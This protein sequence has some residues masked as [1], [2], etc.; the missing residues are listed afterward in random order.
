M[1]MS[2]CSISSDLKRRVRVDADGCKISTIY[3]I[4]F[5]PGVMDIFVNSIKRTSA[6]LAEYSQATSLSGIAAICINSNQT[7][8][9]IGQKFSSTIKLPHDSPPYYIV[10]DFNKSDSKEIYFDRPVFD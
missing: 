10:V 4:H 5:P 8:H 3:F 1:I 9:L 6:T 7:V 2:G